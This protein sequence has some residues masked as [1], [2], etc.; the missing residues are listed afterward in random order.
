[1]D[2]LRH[3]MMGYPL[4]RDYMLALILYTGCDCNYN[5]CSS[6]RNGDYHKWKFFD[7]CLWNAI[8]TLSLKENARYPVYSGLNGVKM[9][10]KVIE[11]GYFVTYVS[12]SW[13]KE[14]SKAFMKDKG[15]MI[16]ID[17]KYRDNNQHG[18]YCC[19]VSWISKF[20]DECEILFARSLQWRDCHNRFKCVILDEV[21]GI[22]TISLKKY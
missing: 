4:S 17:E 14:V 19:D 2:C 10:K 21:N 22:Q 9:D 7:Y 20:P 13:R 3:K 18:I 16:H 1:M 5:L 6:Q 8:C 15:M 11:R 12:T